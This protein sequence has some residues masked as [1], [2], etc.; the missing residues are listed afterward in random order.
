MNRYL[1]YAFVGFVTFA[2]GAYCGGRWIKPTRTSTP[3]VA[4][5]AP[6]LPSETLIS[7]ER[8]GCYGSCPPYTV[9]ISGDGTVIFTGSYVAK[10][11]NEWQ[12][13]GVI[14]SRITQEQLHELLDAF[15]KADYFSLQDSYRNGDDGCPTT[16]TD[17]SSAYT[18]I[19]IDGRMKRVDHYLGC[20]YRSENFESYPKQL[21]ELEE[22]IDRVVNTKQWL[23]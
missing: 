10:S 3:V 7:L 19:Q 16:W 21:T 15:E 14:K 12:R 4:R 11:V 8:T 13:T 20:G 6:A 18:S 1:K 5:S 17:S 2:L 22:T 9:V 23:Q